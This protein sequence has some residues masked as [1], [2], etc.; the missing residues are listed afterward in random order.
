MGVAFHKKTVTPNS[1]LIL[2]I[3]MEEKTFQTTAGRKLLKN[4][5]L[6]VLNSLDYTWEDNLARKR[7][8]KFATGQII[9]TR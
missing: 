1:G 5:L 3:T 8:F 9:G 4:K 7:Y 6:V 2:D